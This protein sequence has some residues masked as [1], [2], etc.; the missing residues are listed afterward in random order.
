M[1]R[2]RIDPLLA[3]VGPLEPGGAEILAAGGAV[4]SG[5]LASGALGDTSAVG[6]PAFTERDPG[7]PEALWGRLRTH[8]LRIR[9]G[10]GDVEESLTELL[11]RWI[12]GIDRRTAP[13]DDLETSLSVSVPSRDVRYVRPLQRFHF[14]QAAHLAIRVDRG[15]E[16]TSMRPA[17]I[18][19]T[20]RTATEFDL[21]ELGRMALDLQRYDAAV[22]AL[23]VRDGALATLTSG[24]A[25]HWRNE[26]DLTWVFEDA[27]GVIRGFTQLDNPEQGAWATGPVIE[28]HRSAYLSFQY[29]EPSAR[30][31]GI[32]SALVEAAHAEAA[33]RG[34]T[35]I[36]VHLAAA[37]P[38]SS[39]FW[40]RH[41]YRPVMTAWFRCPAFTEFD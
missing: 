30:G 24:I 14:T 11:A 23:A 35:A 13:P 27:D 25:D 36:M 12:G 20:I 2:Q 28:A 38:L 10:G 4:G 33:R 41:G 31:T 37:N 5:D 1:D 19:G 6:Q 15:G 3:A 21:P 17:R 29:V 16:A 9:L 32:G 26:P 34:W 40:P 8:S 22:G 39:V 18:F 7:D